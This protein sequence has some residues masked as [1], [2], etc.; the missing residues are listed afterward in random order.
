MF[1]NKYPVFLKG[2]VANH[3]DR[4]KWRYKA[5]IQNNLEIIKGARI[6]D[7]GSCDGRWSF[8]ALKNGAKSITGYEARESSLKIA[9]SNFLQYGIDKNKYQFKQANIDV[10]AIEGKYDV[11]FILGVFYHT[12]S[13]Y[14]ILEKIVKTG[15]KHII[16]DS[17]VN[18]DDQPSIGLKT[19]KG[20]AAQNGILKPNTQHGMALVG[21]PSIKAIEM[22]LHS[23][24]FEKINYFDWGKARGKQLE[25]YEEGLRITLTAQR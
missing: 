5:I 6:I 1:F 18:G 23:F 19:E 4:L 12:L 20:T 22:M 14:A 8:A 17:Q 21:I 11:A 9:E 13:Q 3:P 25:A 10:E 15:V 24:S 16:I 7:L 2:P